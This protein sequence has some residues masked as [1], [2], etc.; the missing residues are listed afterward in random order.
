MKGNRGCDAA[1]QRD[2]EGNSAQEQEKQRRPTKP[3][4]LAYQVRWEAIGA[5]QRRTGRARAV[6]RRQPLADQ[7]C[8][9]A[10]QVIKRCSSGLAAGHGAIVMRDADS[11]HAVSLVGVDL[12]DG[13]ALMFLAFAALWGVAPR[14]GHAS[15]LAA[16]HG[17]V[18]TRV[19][20]GGNAASVVD[21]VGLWG[22][23]D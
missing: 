2:V 10:P 1:E 12:A 13:S 19:V 14:R 18:E 8:R 7:G 22:L 9:G 17:A 6:R 4:V 15:G 23:R 21:G 3:E 16:G 20:T 5:Y 11:R